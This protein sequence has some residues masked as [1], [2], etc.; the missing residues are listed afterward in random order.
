MAVEIEL[1]SIHW[2]TMER[3]QSREELGVARDVLK[4]VRF[5]VVGYDDWIESTAE[6]TPQVKILLSELEWC[7]QTTLL[8]P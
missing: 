6:S 5:E 4:M 7:A 3:S 2:T 1:V 8:W